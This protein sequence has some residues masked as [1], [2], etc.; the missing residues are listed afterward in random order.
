MAFVYWITPDKSLSFLTNGYIGITSS[1]VLR[2]MQSHKTCY[3]RF[4]RGK[5]VS[6]KK[7]Y[8]KIK[9]LGGWDKV[10][11]LTICEADLA[12]CLNLENKLRP[13]PNLGWNTRVGGD[14]AVMFKRE[15]TAETRAKLAQVRKSWTL[16]QV[17]KDKLSK[18][19]KGSGNPMYETLP[20]LNPSGTP[21]SK[22]T[23][24]FAADVYAKWLSFST[25][26]KRIIKSFTNLNYWTLDSMIRKF[27]RG[28]I[29][30]QD[31]AWLTYKDTSN[32]QTS[33]TQTFQY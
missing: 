5:E 27:R 1:N 25:G 30:Q 26:V 23:W 28:W 32:D 9:L 18:E 15:I 6:C 29:P 19:R 24:L 12:Y 10:F 21:L 14:C 17:A 22:F 8:A 2:R 16:S 31:K 4:T 20:W 13:E 11:I 3:S 7:L 33:K